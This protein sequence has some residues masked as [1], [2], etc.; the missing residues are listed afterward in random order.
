MSYGVHKVNGERG[1]VASPEPL[2]T[3]VGIDVLNR[4][5]DAVDAAIAVAFALSV[6]YPSAGNIG[7]GG[8]L[9]CR[10]PQGVAH[11][12]DYRET[13][14]RAATRDMYLDSNGHVISGINGP[15]DGFRACGVPG[16]VAGLHT[17]FQ[18]FG[19]GKVKWR[20]LVQPAVDLARSGFFVSYGLTQSIAQAIDRLALD[21]VC[22][23]LFLESKS[24]SPH[25]QAP[26]PGH[27]LRQEVLAQTLAR[28]RDY[29]ALD[30]YNGKTAHLLSQDIKNKNGII[31]AT[32]MA[33]YTAKVRRPLEGSFAGNSVI[34]M[35]PPSSGGI[36]ILQ[37]L[38]MLGYLPELPETGTANY[39]HILVQI[40]RKAF[41]DRSEYIGDPDFITVP[42]KELLSRQ[43]VANL[44]KGIGKQTPVRFDDMQQ[45]QPLP[46]ESDETT[47]FS[48]VDQ[49]GGCVSN[50]YTL[51]SSF[52]AAV[53][54]ESTG[55]LLNNEMD[56]FT[57][58]VGTANQFGL[59]QGPQNSIVRGKRPLSSMT[60]TIIVDKDGNI[61]LA[62][63]SPGGPTIINTVL[64]TVLE[65][66]LYR[67]PLELVVAAPRFHHQWKP[68]IVY[69]ESTLNHVV[70]ELSY[71]GYKTEIKKLGDV[72]AVTWDRSTGASASSDPRGDGLA[73]AQ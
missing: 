15:V 16:T 7:G 38:G 47:H 68:D 20:D 44:A 37:M 25:V 45:F 54:S 69:L 34:T 9:I 63:G 19:S 43:H 50:T 59:I 10:S 39:V 60:P 56:D 31:D 62:T 71:M 61:L 58:K 35:P 4:G 70:P 36:A 6:T 27:L 65:R 22:K 29:G 1:A 33:N 41:R 28:I 73:L 14:P 52:G 49:Y 18:K 51:N 32:D 57:S 17:A 42:I 40:M 23:S 30:F 53:M 12:V 55:I 21:D 5:G 67:K 3:Q 72:H 64:H 13:A 66:V 26:R 2:A 24:W 8:F 46:Y 11:A 48:V